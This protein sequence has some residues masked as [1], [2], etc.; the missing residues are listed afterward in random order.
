MYESTGKKIVC[1][2]QLN[3]KYIGVDLRVKDTDFCLYN[4]VKKKASTQMYRL[5][6]L[7]FI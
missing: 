4:K 2:L 1:H 3:P 7:H 6:V 5:Y